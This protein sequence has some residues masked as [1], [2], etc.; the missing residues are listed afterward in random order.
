MTLQNSRKSLP[1]QTLKQFNLTILIIVGVIVF[2]VAM[3]KLQTTT[4]THGDLRL[5]T[6]DE[7]AAAFVRM[8]LSLSEAELAELTSLITKGMRMLAPGER[9]QLEKLQERYVYKGHKRFSE[10][11]VV[12]M[13]QLNYKGINLLSEEDQSRFHYLMLKGTGRLSGD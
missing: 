7:A 8:E 1:S 12:T 2:L 13:R 3:K 5:R 10:R 9:A 4:P 11:D 6:T